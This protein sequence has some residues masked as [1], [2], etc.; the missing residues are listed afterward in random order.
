MRVVRPRGPGTMAVTVPASTR[1]RAIGVLTV[2]AAL[3]Y[4]TDFVARGWIPPDEGMLAQSAERVL[5]GQIPHVGYEEPYTGG[6]SWIY[7]ALFRFT[8]VELLHIRWL[9]YI[10][11]VV[12]MYILYAL[13]RR[14]LKPPAAAVATWVGLAW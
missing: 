14:F 10:V 5:L 6:L 8:G 2:A 12:A 9:L 11:A 13:L 7:A 1:E 4:L 3:V